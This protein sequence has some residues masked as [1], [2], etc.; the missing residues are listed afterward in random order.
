MSSN[1]C[2]V[3]KQILG[4]QDESSFYLFECGHKVH[5]LCFNSESSQCEYDIERNFIS[6]STCKKRTNPLQNLFSCF[7][8][9]I[10][11]CIG[12]KKLNSYIPL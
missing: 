3:C 6:C 12:K 7:M 2:G 4:D 10:L 5:V 11:N 1:K 9:S 8:K